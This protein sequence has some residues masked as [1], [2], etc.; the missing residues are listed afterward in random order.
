MS[1]HVHRI[2]FFDVTSLARNTV[3]VIPRDI[4]R[5]LSFPFTDPF[6]LFQMRSCSML[7]N[8]VCII[9]VSYTVSGHPFSFLPRHA[10]E[11][12]AERRSIGRQIVE[13]NSNFLAP[14]SEYG[15]RSADSKVTNDNSFL[16]RANILSRL[17]KRARDLDREKS[18]RSI[19][20]KS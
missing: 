20:T 2:S 19:T 10:V 18:A 13:H 1:F 17:D 11:R 5:P 7:I 6:C 9:T 4:Y 12:A 16:N 8:L 3:P 15:P 14:L